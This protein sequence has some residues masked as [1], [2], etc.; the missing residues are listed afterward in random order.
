MRA[1]DPFSYYP[2]CASAVPG[3]GGT[4]P[5][6]EPGYCFHTD[7][8]A[9]R[10]GIAT[11]QVRL[12]GVEASRGRLALRVHALRRDGV[13]NA[14]FVAGAQVD[15]RA[16][17]GRELCV[18]VQFVAEPQMHYAFYG[19]FVRETDLR[20]V[21]LD[22]R[23][24]ERPGQGHAEPPPSVLASALDRR[25]ALQA[26]AL[27]HVLSHPLFAPVSQD[28]T[29]AQMAELRAGDGAGT[30]GLDDWAEAL[31]LNA[32]RVHGATS[33]AL[34]GL[35]IGACSPEFLA[36]LRVDGAHVH[37]LPAIP[38]PDADST[39]FGDFL[40]WPEGLQHGL[41]SAARWGAIRDWFAR[42]KLGGIGVMTCRFRPRRVAL[43][44]VEAIDDQMVT[45][46]EIERWAV[47]LITEG[48]SV[49]PLVFSAPEELQIDDDGLACFALIARRS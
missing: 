14:R 6:P 11:Y 28:C 26:R 7:Y 8:V 17:Q 49:D 18:G 35:V 30:G 46:S 38:P 16:D 45:R 22:V 33:A 48:Y 3:L 21:S 4:E 36:M 41:D 47:Q 25:E 5:P 9:V 40:V 2:G 23:L 32:L 29:I 43:G 10:P 24:D 1:I 19:K 34:E 12:D 39:L 15:V 27:L 31:C 42:L 20:A 44:A 37:M 13:G